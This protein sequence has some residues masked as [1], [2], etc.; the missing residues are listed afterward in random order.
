MAPPVL[1]YN[2]F[3]K[4]NHNA[5]DHKNKRSNKKTQKN[6][7]H[8]QR[9]SAHDNQRLQKTTKHDQQAQTDMFVMHSTKLISAEGGRRGEGGEGEA[10]EVV[11]SR[12]EEQTVQQGS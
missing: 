2:D 5:N 4:Q 12:P 11:R 10:R 1:R 9:R 7:S 3:K 8:D 6:N